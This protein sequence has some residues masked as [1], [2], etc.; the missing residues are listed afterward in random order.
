MPGVK[1]SEH[2]RRL[3]TEWK[4]LKINTDEDS[5]NSKQ[6]QKDIYKKRRKDMRQ[7]NKDI[8]ENGGKKYKQTE[9]DLAKQKN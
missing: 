8:I 5:N 3:I 6:V 2:K 4:I 9:K 1:L 7:K